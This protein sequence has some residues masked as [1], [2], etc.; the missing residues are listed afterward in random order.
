VLK[1]SN[2]LFLIKFKPQ[3]VDTGGKTIEKQA[4]KLLQ[5]F[6]RNKANAADK[7]ADLSFKLFIA[8]IV[9]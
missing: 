4:V 9:V 8:S 1:S 7:E 3:M 2:A 6:L 5:K